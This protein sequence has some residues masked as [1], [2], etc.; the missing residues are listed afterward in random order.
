M[1]KK[2]VAKL[3]AVLAAAYPKFEVDDL[4]VHVWHEMLQDIDYEVA[5]VAAKKLILE[6]TFP[7]SIAEVR[8]A[9]TSIT[10]PP[11]VLP[12]E[13]W[14][15]VKCAIRKYGSYREEEALA[16]L[17]ERTREAVRCMDWQELCLSQD[18][19]GVLRAQFMRIYEQVSGREVQERLMPADLQEQIK[20]L[21]ARKDL[22]LIEGWKE[23][24][25]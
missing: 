7:P 11:Q 20:K 24:A 12:A 10:S 23:E 14:G 2:E 22:R 16:S 19:E 1:T 4:K 15:E 8:E 5:G 3:L 9:I 25:H 18:P 13:A 6:K 17:S 21:S